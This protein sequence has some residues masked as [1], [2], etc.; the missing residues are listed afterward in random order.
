M[1]YPCPECG[2][3]LKDFAGVV[4]IDS[5]G[6]NLGAVMSC[7]EHGDYSTT[8]PGSTNPGHFVQ[9]TAVPEQDA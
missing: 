8:N 2:K 1:G 9:V 5:D 4:G 7:A 6:N 3:D